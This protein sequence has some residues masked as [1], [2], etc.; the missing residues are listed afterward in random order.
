MK[1]FSLFANLEGPQRQEYRCPQPI[2]ANTVKL[3][4]HS[5]VS[6]QRDPT[7]ADIYVYAD[8][9]LALSASHG[10]SMYDSVSAVKVLFTNAGQQSTVPEPPDLDGCILQNSAGA[11]AF[12]E[13]ERWNPHHFGWANWSSVQGFA[14]LFA[15][16]YACD[17]GA[18]DRISGSLT[19]RLRFVANPVIIHGAAAYLYREH[20]NISSTVPSSMQP[21][22]CLRGVVQS[23][24][25][26]PQHSEGQIGA[27]SSYTSGTTLS[28]F[29]EIEPHSGGRPSM[30]PPEEI[31]HFSAP[32][33]D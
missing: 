24:N 17:R 16:E 25:W 31:G 3:Q 19:A 7:L 30:V 28:Q 2:P 15:A 6:T 10:T 1:C 23:V 8:G 33:P 22:T 4:T 29:N 5:S 21:N 26:L 11:D 18:M 13:E 20:G 27:N 32:V 14:R 12:V 9:H